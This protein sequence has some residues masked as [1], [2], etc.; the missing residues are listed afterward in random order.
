MYA[1]DSAGNINFSSVT[2]TINFSELLT[3]AVHPL[4][5]SVITSTTISLNASTNKEATSCNYSLDEG[6]NILTALY[7]LFACKKDIFKFLHAFFILVT[8][9]ITGSIIKMLPI[10]KLPSPLFFLN[11]LH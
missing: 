7:S 5:N 1:N 11:H 8:T 6:I 4:H 3:T 9:G 2:F 10:F